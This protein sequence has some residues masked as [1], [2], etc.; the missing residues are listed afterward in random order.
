MSAV[1]EIH[2]PAEV[3]GLKDLWTR[4]LAASGSANIFLSWEWMANWLD[5]VGFWGR[6]RVLLVRDG[7]GE[8]KGL[9]P[10]FAERAGQ[11]S[12]APRRLRFMGTGFGADHL[13]FI[14]RAGEDITPEVV[15]W[16]TAGRRGWD[17]VELRW[18]AEQQAQRLAQALAAHNGAYASALEAA[19]PSPLL[20][21][22]PSWEEYRER[23]GSNLRANLGRYRRKLEREH[24]AAF[25]C[26]RTPEELERVWAAL[27]ALHQTRWRDRGQPGSFVKPYFEILHHRFA[28]IALTQ[29][30]LRLYYLEARD[31]VIAALYCFRYGARVS[32]F[33]AGFHP[34]WAG[35]GPGRL[36]MA[37]AIRSAIEEGAAEFDFMRGGE[38]HKF[39]WSPEV[40]RDYHVTIYRL[41]P[42]VLTAL[43][44]Q[45]GVRLLRR[46]IRQIL[47]ARFLLRAQRAPR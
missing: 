3:A 16:L 36:L 6:P 34:A 31:R 20:R 17:I 7:A 8:V 10:L 1:E 37:H 46:G 40:R 32:Y 22:P 9:A 44:L 41:H 12:L 33:Q 14:A 15:T 28:R 45:G 39:R 47:Q 29:G 19:D 24:G 13:G 27:V 35:Y 26:V 18:Q 30:W 43:R 23:L 5:L 4:L 38:D 25:R 21:L 42:R 11:A 2:T